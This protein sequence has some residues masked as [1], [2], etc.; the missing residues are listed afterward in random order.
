MPCTIRNPIP[1]CDEGYYEKENKK[2][3]ICCYKGEKKTK[4]KCTKINPEPPCILGYKPEDRG[5]GLC[6]YK[7]IK[8]KKKIKRKS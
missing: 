1:P 5:K 3:E 6:C 4:K 7:K 8:E 2:G